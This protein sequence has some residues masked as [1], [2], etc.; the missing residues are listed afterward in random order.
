MKRYKNELLLLVLLLLG[1]IG[2]TQAKV[3]FP[4]IGKLMPD[5]ELN[6]V[7]FYPQKTL[8]NKDFKNK[9]YIL[10]FWTMGCVPCIESFPKVNAMVKEFRDKVEIIQVGVGDH[11]LKNYYEAFRLKQNLNIPMAFDLK[12]ASNWQ[13]RSYPLIF[14]VDDK[15]IL[16]VVTNEL[17]REKLTLLINGKNT[18]SQKK[19]YKEYL[20][21]TASKLFFLNGN[22]GNDTSFLFRSVI[23][24]TTSD[25]TH[26]GVTNLNNLNDPGLEVNRQFFDNVIKKKGLY[27]LSKVSLMALYNIAY[28]GQ[29]RIGIWDSLYRNYNWFS[30]Y[31]RQTKQWWPYLELKDSSDFKTN[32]FSDQG[33]YTYSLKMPPEKS[34]KESVMRS[35]RL[36]LL[37]YFGYAAAVEIRRIPIWKLVVVDKN[38]PFENLKTK[39]AKPEFLF[40]NKS[41]SNLKIVNY[42][43][44]DLLASIWV[45]N[46]TTH[47]FFNETNIDYNIDIFIE[48]PLDD[49]ESLRKDLQKYGLDLVKGEKEMKV[50][51]I[52]DPKPGETF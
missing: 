4:T 32:S 26:N 1:K 23:A 9:W 49:L 34:T 7:D 52:R 24:K 27:Q 50:L 36:D 22:G 33:F 3:E 31:D 45:Q 2:F 29:D 8:T 30:S 10:D 39:G 51:V 44:N 15:G 11:Q 14:I 42:S 20:P 6:D 47:P 13:V 16:R 12:H 40:D 48:S 46:Q 41:R 18:F 43:V 38:K 28:F 19:S 21:S 37:K 35:M 25:Y 17:N 5:F